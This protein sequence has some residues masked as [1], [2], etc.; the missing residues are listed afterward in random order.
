MFGIKYFLIPSLFVYM[1]GVSLFAQSQKAEVYY[2]TLD[3]EVPVEG[4]PVKKYQRGQ[5]DV[6]ENGTL[7]QVLPEFSYQTMKGIGGCFNEIGGLA[8]ASLPE[9]K[10]NEIMENLF[11]LENAGFT[12]CRTA[13]GSSD[14]G[15]SAYSYAEKEGDYKMNSFSVE[16]EEKSVIPYIQKAIKYNPELTLFASP[17]SPPG[18]LKESGKMEWGSSLKDTPETYQAYALYLQKYIEEYAKRGISIHRLLVQNETDCVVNYPSCVFPPEQMI[19]FINGYL[20]PL[21]KQKHVETEIWGG[22]YRVVDGGT[23]EALSVF[24]NPDIRKHDKGVGMQYQDYNHLVDFRLLYPSIPLMHTESECFNGDNSVEQAYSRLA[25]I[26]K[27]VT[28]GAENFAY[29]NMILDENRA[30]GWGWKQNSLITV[31]RTSKEVTY[32]PDYAVM[33]LISRFV[34]PGDK[35]IAH[36][37]W[38]SPTF[39]V[40]SP[41]GETRIFLVNKEEKDKLITLRISGGEDVRICIPPRSLSVVVSGKTK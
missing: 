6:S 32:H 39:A 23:Y 13:V 8:L 40:K 24:S 29:W 18:W 4:R 27:Y 33:S 3:E 16:R 10:Q 5:T 21:F 28:A 30:S 38:E 12:F 34:R 20:Y 35:R 7:V 9:S 31:N 22:T 19:K 15:V 17:W 14:F 36:I 37:Y 1:G 26:A 11:S 2:V 25:E 41:E